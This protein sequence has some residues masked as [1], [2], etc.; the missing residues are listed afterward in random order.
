[1]LVSIV[2]LVQ[3]DPPEGHGNGARIVPAREVH[4]S[5]PATSCQTPD[6]TL[7]VSVPSSKESESKAATD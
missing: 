3:P 1:M 5:E 4:W 2:Q 6:C 7:H